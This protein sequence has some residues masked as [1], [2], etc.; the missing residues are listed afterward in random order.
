MNS[1]VSP[2]VWNSQT[3]KGII[4]YAMNQEKSQ[5]NLKCTNS[6]QSHDHSFFIERQMKIQ[7]EYTA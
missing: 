4:L 2:Q 7:H 1:L 3:Q 5:L 6:S